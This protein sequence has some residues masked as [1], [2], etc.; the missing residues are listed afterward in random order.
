MLVEVER[1][2]SIGEIF[3]HRIRDALIGEIGKRLKKTCPESAILGHTAEERFAVLLPHDPRMANARALSEELQEALTQPYHLEE[4]L[5][6]IGLF[7][8]FA[9]GQSEEKDVH[10]LVERCY[11][12]LGN[13][14]SL[15]AGSITAY[16]T[17]VAQKVQGYRQLEIDFRKAIESDEIEAHYQPILDANTRS[18][19]GFEALARW[20]HPQKGLLMPDLFVPLAEKTGLIDKLSH[21]M[22]EL[23][24]REA[25]TWPKDVFL[26]LNLSAILFDDFDIVETIT[27]AIE[28][29]GFAASRVELEITE[30]VFLS[31]ERLVDVLKSFQAIGMRVVIDDF[32]TGF[33]SLSYL[34]ALPFDKIKIDRSF[35]SEMMIS[36]DARAIVKAITMLAHEL[37]M[38]IV[39]EGVE[40][41]HQVEILGGFGC[42]QLQGYLFSKPVEASAVTSL[43]ATSVS[44][45]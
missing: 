37:G 31:D 45:A 8:G 43:L 5:I 40:N 38:E 12:A 19:I 22:I 7:I 42:D 28:R 13:S 30:S 2:H 15:G 23:A 39:A 9:S 18:I 41:E 4:H 25:S 21:R 26:A 34:R 36:P 11:I 20:R 17:A 6:G 10:D 24:C 27:R 29:T 1:F 44:G 33:S 14:R 3:G 16:S 32:G 35:V